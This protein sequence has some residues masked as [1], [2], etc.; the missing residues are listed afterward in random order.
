MMIAAIVKIWLEILLG[1][2]TSIPMKLKIVDT[3]VGSIFL[4]LISKPVF[5]RVYE[6]NPNKW[7][8]RTYI[9]T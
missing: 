5:F 3:T 2:A 6:R 7:K 9:N 4:S 8:H 1:L